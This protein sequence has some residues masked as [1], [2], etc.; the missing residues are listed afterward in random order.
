MQ[1]HC[2]GLQENR[3]PL[4]LSL[5]KTDQAV[6]SPHRELNYFFVSYFTF[7]VLI[8][9]WIIVW[10][11]R[12]VMFVRTALVQKHSHC[13]PQW[14][15]SAN[16]ALVRSCAHVVVHMWRIVMVVRVLASTKTLSCPPQWPS[17]NTALVRGCEEKHPP[18]SHFSCF[19]NITFYWC[20]F[21]VRMKWLWSKTS[22]SSHSSC[23]RL[24]SS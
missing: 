16:T 1:W 7:V 15:S 23:F 4:F 19:G 6:G 8:Y 20:Q 12:I 24:F 11:G 3:S 13:P 14:P 18:Y 21:K 5:E 17:A 10:Y 2:P 9:F 22:Q